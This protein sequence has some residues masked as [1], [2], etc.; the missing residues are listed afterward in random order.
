MTGYYWQGFYH[1]QYGIDPSDYG[2]V[3]SVGA[4]EWPLM[5]KSTNNLPMDNVHGA[6]PP[7]V[8]PDDETVDPQKPDLTCTPHPTKTR[9][10]WQAV[11][12]QNA[13]GKPYAKATALYNKH[14]KYSEQWNP[15]H[16]F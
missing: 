14:R 16:P 10:H 3:T 11:G 12:V 15:R 2:S 9:A 1:L 6:P 4:P 7:E 8:T 5:S 13:G